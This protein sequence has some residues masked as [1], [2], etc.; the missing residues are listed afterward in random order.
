MISLSRA[1]AEVPRQL[2]YSSGMERP[3]PDYSHRLRLRSGRMERC[4]EAR[5]RHWRES[6][7]ATSVVNWRKHA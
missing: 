1:L 7:D 6:D 4:V 2:S 3:L 5:L